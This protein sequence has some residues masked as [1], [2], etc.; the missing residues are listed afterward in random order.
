MARG[1]SVGFGLP[2]GSCLTVRVAP[3]GGSPTLIRNE[4]TNLE[5]NLFDYSPLFQLEPSILQP[6]P[7]L[8]TL[9]H[10]KVTYGHV[11]LDPRSQVTV[12]AFEQTM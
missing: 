6:L 11:L 2:D 7:V 4:P 12:V 3:S 8:Q 10:R 9:F 5:P 1:A